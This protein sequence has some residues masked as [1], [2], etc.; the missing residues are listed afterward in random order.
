MKRYTSKFLKST[1]VGYLA[2]PLV[3]LVAAALLF[4]I[5]APNCMRILLSPTFY[6]LSGISMLAGYG[7]WEMRRWAWYVFLFSIALTLYANA[8]LAADYGESHHKGVAFFVGLVALGGLVFRVGREVRVP[9]F[10]PKIRWWESD[11][12]YKLS[13][14]AHL[15]RSGD[16]ARLD[17]EILDI[18]GSGCFLKLRVELIQDENVMVE[19]TMFGHAMSCAGAVVWRTQSAVTHPKG[20]GVKFAG[21]GKPQKRTLRAVTERLRRISS[22]YT[23]SRYLMSQEEF[24]R[25]LTELQTTKLEV[26][27]NSPKVT[28]AG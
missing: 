16:G 14:P 4:D 9:Y 1:A 22:L 5:P 8:I 23:S 24:M 15:V 28:R 19:F 6:L 17:C 21:L 18:S 27:E 26:L 11:P 10:L 3:Y 2:F 20:I 13:V 7:F 25:R 12:R